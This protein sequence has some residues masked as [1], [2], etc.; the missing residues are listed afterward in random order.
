MFGI[1]IGHQVDQ[2]GGIGKQG[3]RDSGGPPTIFD[4]R[5]VTGHDQHDTD[6]DQRHQR[7][8]A[9]QK[10]QY[11]ADEKE[12]NAD[13]DERLGTLMRLQSQLGSGIAWRGHRAVVYPCD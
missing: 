4:L 7:P 13:A 10:R 12:W 6:A 9:I 11:A 8:F 3:Q 1:G 2:Q 5:Q